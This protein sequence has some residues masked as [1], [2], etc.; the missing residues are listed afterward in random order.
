M[1]RQQR[2]SSAIK[3]LQGQ[4]YTVTMPQTTHA[5]AVTSP[6]SVPAGGVQAQPVKIIITDPP[7]TVK[8]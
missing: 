4:G 2:T 8:G 3:H 7:P 1:T 6:A 5:P